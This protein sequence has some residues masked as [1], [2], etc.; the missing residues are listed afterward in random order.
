VSSAPLGPLR[1]DLDPDAPVTVVISRVVRPGREADYASWVRGVGRVLAGFDGAEAYTVLPPGVHHTGA[2][3]IIVLRFRDP[4]AVRRWRRSEERQRWLA[5]L[6]DLTIDAGAWEEQTGL[7]TWF[8][9]TDRPTPTGPPPRWKQAT[10]T[11]IG[12]VPLLLVADLLLGGVTGG[13]PGWLRT[14]LVTPVLVALMTWAIMPT[15]TRASYR[16]LYPGGGS[17]R[18]GRS[19]RRRLSGRAR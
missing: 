2:E 5:Q 7:E 12:L 19:G 9:L 18:G 17:R 1:D 16:W 8:T 4:D 10:L 14:V 3:W 11:T 13:W 6:D 15:I